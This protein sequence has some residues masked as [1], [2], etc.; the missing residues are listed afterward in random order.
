MIAHFC[1]EIKQYYM[2]FNSASLKENAHVSRERCKTNRYTD[3]EYQSLSNQIFK[4]VVTYE[5]A[6]G[7]LSL[8]NLM[9]Q[10]SVSMHFNIA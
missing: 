8:Q 10:C 1:D 2:D 4:T 9:S 7:R 3:T 6:I 5:L